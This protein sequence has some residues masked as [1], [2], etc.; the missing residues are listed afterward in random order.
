MLQTTIV[1]D[2]IFKALRVAGVAYFGDSLDPAQ[3]NEALMILNAIRAEYSINLRANL[4]YDQT[5]TAVA[6]TQF[7]TLGTDYSIPSAPVAGMIPIRPSTIDQIVVINGSIGSPSASNNNFVIPI[8]T[9]EEYRAKVVQNV[10]AVP[11]G[12]YID[13]EYPL[14]NIYLYPGLTA[15]W[16]IRV[17]GRRYFTDY[18]SIEDPYIDPPEYFQMLYLELATRLLTMYGQ[19]IPAGLIT[20]LNGVS[21][22]IKAKN[23]KAGMQRSK[24]DLNRNGTGINFLAG[25]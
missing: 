5:Y 12:A 4:K 21:K 15:G 6:N 1:Y 20:Q 17:E 18:E 8:Y 14:R 13:T 22:A 19:D 16:S 23:F 7:V 3:S 2:L 24:N 10:F 9:Y 25:V 11:L